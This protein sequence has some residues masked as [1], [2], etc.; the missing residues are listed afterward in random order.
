MTNSGP[1]HRSRGVLVRTAG[2]IVTLCLF[3]GCDR[4]DDHQVQGYVEG[5]FVYVASPLAGSLQMLSVQRG[6]QVAAG[7]PLFDTG[8]A[9]RR[10]RRKR[11]PSRV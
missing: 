3:A 4:T 2:M 10:K 6:A 7:D 1:V 9:R 11:K 8:Q 5:E